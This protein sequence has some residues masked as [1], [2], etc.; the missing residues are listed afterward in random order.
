MR[1]KT[2]T[3]RLATIHQIERAF[4]NSAPLGANARTSGVREGP[5]PVFELELDKQLVSEARRLKLDVES[6]SRRAIESAVRDARMRKWAEDNRAI[7][8]AKAKLVEEQG[9]WSDGLRQF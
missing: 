7:F 9:L 1:G 2:S 8:E 5:R 4:K 3:L 6:I